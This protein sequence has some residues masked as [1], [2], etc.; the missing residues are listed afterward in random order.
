MFKR[1]AGKGKTVIDGDLDIKGNGWRLT[2]FTITGSVKI[3]GN[4]NDI[5]G[6]ELRRPSRVDIRGNNN[7][8]P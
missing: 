2:G 3:R 8:T 7:R 4:N 5:S 1:G 6:C